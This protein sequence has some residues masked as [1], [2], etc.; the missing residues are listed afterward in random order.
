MKK[1]F[2][3][4]PYIL[5]TT[6]LFTIGIRT[7]LAIPYELATS[8]EKYKIIILGLLLLTLFIVWL[9]KGTR[10]SPPLLFVAIIFPVYYLSINLFFKENIN[11]YTIALY[12]VWIFYVF[13]LG[14]YFIKDDR[15]L[16]KYLFSTIIASGAI[17]LWGGYS[18][19]TG[20]VSAEVGI[21]GRFTMGYENPNYYSQYWQLLFISLILLYTKMSK[22]IK[23]ISIVLMICSIYFVILANSRNVLIW[24]IVFLYWYYSY[25]IPGKN[26]LKVFML[27]II[28]FAFT[29]LSYEEANS[30][31]SG[32]ILLWGYKINEM[33]KQTPL[34][35]FFGAQDVIV[36]SDL[37]NTYSRLSED[38]VFTKLHADNSYLELY[39]EGGVIGM[40]LFFAPYYYVYKSLK[41]TNNKEK[42]LFFSIY[43]GF[44]AQSLFTTTITSFFSPLAMF[45]SLLL[46][47]PYIKHINKTKTHQDPRYQY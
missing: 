17:L 13:L 32:R 10:K 18:T 37:I 43:F 26:M 8:L 16:N 44:L 25:R 47:L 41:F 38:V 42:R 24:I 35:I 22:S 19:L 36:T 3:N 27:L 20:I 33:L 6:L 39:M 7:S 40:I 31:S 14:Q 29:T 21:E 46:I 9:Y 28:I 1:I 23:V 45:M 5:Y 4:I 34:T 30:L 2:I 12:F 15:K 11:S